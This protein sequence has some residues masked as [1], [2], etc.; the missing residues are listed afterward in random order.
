MTQDTVRARDHERR[1]RS[2]FA[3][4]RCAFNDRSFGELDV[5]ARENAHIGCNNMRSAARLISA[6][7]K[8]TAQRVSP[9]QE[10]REFDEFDSSKLTA[11]RAERARARQVQ[12]DLG[13]CSCCCC[14]CSRCRRCRFVALCFSGFVSSCKQQQRQR[15]QEHA[16]MPAAKQRQQQQLPRDE[17]QT[18]CFAL[19]ADR[20]ETGELVRARSP[21]ARD[22]PINGAPARARASSVACVRSNAASR[23]DAE[24]HLRSRAFIRQKRTRQ[25]LVF[26]AN[27]GV[28]QRSRCSRVSHARTH[29]PKSHATI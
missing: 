27:A 20:N 5:V 19:P 26:A 4:S 1:F 29:A 6:K 22:D 17:Q 9:A 8:I 24:S 23:D 3:G 28:A 18:R 2:P 14:C 12:V 25:N 10:Q 16:S 15:K 7:F 21:R 11:E 13:F